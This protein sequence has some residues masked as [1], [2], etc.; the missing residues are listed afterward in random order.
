LDANAIMIDPLVPA[1]IAGEL[2]QA[3]AA[4][5]VPFGAKPPAVVPA[6]RRR[7]RRVFTKQGRRA[8]TTIVTAAV[9]LVAMVTAWIGL[10]AEVPLIAPPLEV[11]VGLLSLFGGVNRVIAVG[12]AIDGAN[13]AGWRT[14][15]RT[16]DPSHPS[17]DGLHAV[18]AY[19]RQYVEPGHDMDANARAAWARAVV[20][21]NKAGQSDVVRLGLVDS[22]QVT[23]VLPH[24]LWD[25]AERLARLSA[26]RAQH[27]DILRGVDP[28]DPDVATLLGPQRRAHELATADIEQRVAQLEV[29]AQLT[30]Q[31]DAARRREA[32]VRQLATLNDSHAE[33]IARI[34]QG[35]APDALAEQM[36]VDV[37]ALID[38]A[39]EA[40]RQANEAGRSLALPERELSS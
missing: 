31:A 9:F 38:Q 18:T 11:L 37:Q 13:A 22:V 39:N 32:A 17:W 29:F 28:D 10:A 30:S 12:R 6:R 40:V 34:G 35:A 21:A 2:A 24:H 20:A 33:L 3:P 1:D 14:R 25:I 4:R 7:R 16:A 5:L 26:L 23:T 36:S 8:V 15:A 19:H 27:K